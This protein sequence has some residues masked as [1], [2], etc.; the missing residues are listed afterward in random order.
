MFDRICLE[1]SLKPFKKTDKNYIEKI[2]S[3]I[4]G[5]WKALLDNRKEISIMLWAGDGSEILEYNRELNQSFEWAYWVGTANREILKEGQPKYTSLHTCKQLYIENP[6]V[7]TYKILKDI[8]SS[9]KKIGKLY[10]PK[11]KITVGETFDIG[12]EFAVSDFKYNRHKEICTGSKLDSFGFLDSTALLNKD[13]KPYAAYPDGIPQDTPFAE[14]LGKQSEV[15]LKDMDFDY[16]WLSNGLGF[17]SNPW[18]LT[19]KIFDGKEFKI[20]NLEKIKN[21]VFNFWR[22]L[23]KELPDIPIMVRGTN[24]SAGIDYATDGVPLYDIYKSGFNITPP[25]NSPWSALTDDFGLEIMGHLTRIC[26]LPGS[27]IFYRY[28]IH[29]PWWVNTP[30]YDRYNSSPHDIYLPLALSRIDENGNVAAA[31]SLNIL[32]IDN[33]F[34]DMPKSCIYE[35]LPH[36]LKAEKDLPDDIPPLVWVYPLREYTTSR[37]ETALKEMYFG[38]NFIKR[39]INNGLFLSSVISSDNILGLKANCF[40]KSILISPVPETKEVLDKLQEFADSG[41]NIAFYGS[42]EYAESKKFNLDFTDIFGN[43][44]LLEDIEK[45]NFSI[46]FSKKADIDKNIALTVSCHDNGYIFS[47]YNPNLTTDTLM[48][49]P[50]GAPILTGYDCEIKDGH[51]VYRFPMSVHS[52]CRVFVN[53]EDTV[54]S[55][56]ECPP[57]NTVFHRKLLLSGLKNAAVYVF[58]ESRKNQSVSFSNNCGDDTP[59]FDERFKRI[60][61]DKWGVLYKAENITGECMILFPF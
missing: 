51:S 6:P 35:P 36:I 10:F 59:V 47:V 17:S 45:F 58:P 38:D 25:P 9:F 52:E 57:V 22:I 15:F 7:M 61:D 1:V 8:I 55:L 31:N 27:D 28:Y 19:G 2:C 5:S 11:S 32:S 14:F 30:W 20:N 50:L 18:D 23:V 39:E 42:K 4:Y 26:E 12:P 54:I 44:S 13:S 34:G 53:S 48:R 40:K 24:N 16:L 43:E 49:F 37:S 41:I 29:D 56:K 21:D 33:S 46:K 60:E 3:E